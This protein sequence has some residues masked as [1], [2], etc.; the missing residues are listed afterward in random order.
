M[1]CR[2]WQRLHDNKAYKEVE[3]EEVLEI[4]V[5]RSQFLPSIAV[6]LLSCES[7]GNNRLSPKEL[8]G[9]HNIYRAI[10]RTEGSVN[11]G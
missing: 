10:E 9:L 2:Y 7:S 6:S 11:H 4:I 1:A 8:E 5:Q 3:F